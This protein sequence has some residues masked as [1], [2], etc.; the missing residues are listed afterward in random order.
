MYSSLSNKRSDT[1]IFWRLIYPSLRPY[2]IVLRL[3]ISAFSK[4]K[5]GKSIVKTDIFRDFATVKAQ[6]ILSSKTLV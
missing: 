3:L 1:P 2:W 5:F 4:K 6:I